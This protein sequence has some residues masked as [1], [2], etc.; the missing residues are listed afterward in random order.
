V[1]DILRVAIIYFSLTGNTQKVTA[2]I[3]RQLRESN[4]AVEEIRLR[5]GEGTFLGNAARALVRSQV[6]VMDEDKWQL[7]PFDFI[8]LGSPGWAFSPTPA[9]NTFLD[10]CRGLK[11]KKWA[12][13]V[14]YGSGL[15]KEKA[16]QIMKGILLDKGAREVYPLSL[17]AKLVKDG[18]SLEKRVKYF[19]DSLSL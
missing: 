16:L 7:S 13:F 1:R 14:T 12:I 2:E 17:S 19:L 18:K 3:S 5:G 8:F 4:I 11:D 10:K 6:K 15:G 9:V